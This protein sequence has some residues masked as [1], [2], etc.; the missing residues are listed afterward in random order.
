MRR[1]TLP[2]ASKCQANSSPRGEK[3]KNSMTTLVWAAYS[4]GISTK[5]WKKIKPEVQT[6]LLFWRETWMKLH[7]LIYSCHYQLLSQNQI[8]RSCIIPWMR[9]SFQNAKGRHLTTSISQRWRLT[10]W[11]LIEM[12]CCYFKLIRRFAVQD[13]KRQLS[14]FCSLRESKIQLLHSRWTIIEPRATSDI[15]PNRSPSPSTRPS[16]LYR[17]IEKCRYRCQ[18]STVSKWSQVRGHLVTHE[19]NINL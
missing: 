13:R 5:K 4:P 6:T 3:A 11:S 17:V 2:M 14:N 10:N 12:A 19:I 7:L 16:R 18:A 8:P 9:P 15:N 1:L